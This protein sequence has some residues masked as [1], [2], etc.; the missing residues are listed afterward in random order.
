MT[1]PRVDQI[2]IALIRALAMTLLLLPGPSLSLAQNAD[3]GFRYA[4]LPL[5]EALQALQARGLRIVFTSQTVKPELRVEQEPKASDPRVVLT[6]LLSAHDLTVEPGPGDRLIV[7]K[8]PPRPVSVRGRTLDGDSGAGVRGVRVLIPGTRHST[9]S[10]SEGRFQLPNIPVRLLPAGTL[11]LEARLPGFVVEHIE[12]PL[13]P[14]EVVNV[15]FELSPAPLTVDQIVVVPSQ[16]TLLRDEPVSTVQL[17]RDDLF[18]LPHLGD[19]IFRAFTLLPGVAGEEVSARFHVRG[20]HGD[21]VLVLLDQVELFEPYHMKDYSSSL[22]IIAPS[23]LREVNLMTGGFPAQYGDRMS[24]VLD[25]TTRQPS[26]TRTHLGLGV[27]SAEIGV[28]GTFASDRG[29]WFASARR[30]N[31]DLALDFLGSREQPRYWDAIAKAEL[32]PRPE[33]L[34]GIRALHSDDALDFDAIEPD[35]IEDYRTSYGN[36][37]L[38][39]THQAILGPRLFVDTA[40]SA[41]RVRRDRRGNEIELEEDVPESGAS[42][43]DAVLAMADLLSGSDAEADDPDGE[44]LDEPG[45]A[46]PGFTLVDKRR[47]DALGVRQDWSYQASDDHYLTWGFEARRLITDYDYFNA[48]ELEDPLA[49]LRTEPRTGTVRFQRRLE[50]EQYSVY[51]SDRLRPRDGLTLELGLRYDEQ[52]LTRDRHASP[53]ANLVYALSPS[54]TVRAAWGFFYQSQRPYELQVE[55]GIN[56][57]VQAERTEQRVLGYEQLLGGRANLLLRVEAYHRLISNPRPRYENVYEPISIYPEVEPD[58]F[59][60]TPES[61]EAYGLE[62]FLRGRAGSRVDWWLSYTYARVFDR[63]A[64]Q[65][66]RDVPRRID[67]P[68]AL[69]LDANLQL[70]E[71]WNLNLAWRYHTGWPTTEISGRLEDDEDGEVQVVPVFGPRN[72]E[73]L[74]AYH[75]LDLRAS[76]EWQRRT[77]V[78]G[79]FLEIQNVYDR[80]NVAGF[81]TD[82]EFEVLPDGSVHFLPVEEPWGG[83]LPSFGVT[84]DF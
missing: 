48:R 84:W 23:A 31:L 72:A 24:G 22:S 44:D 28:S 19:D 36:S 42:A 79:F 77:G 68:H 6:E 15:A 47:L 64:V 20:G 76:R 4:G 11:T 54:S 33:Q 40:V 65:P 59:L 55:D 39:L 62:L 2:C 10:D 34:I 50:G 51:V 25:M 1:R 29:H 13:R 75:R 60:V 69:N 53:R 83:F 9:L 27:L 56:E 58:R 78:L 26:S 17:D 14:G 80:K 38:W 3:S 52:T 7:V 8:A 81:D 70:G 74:P 66:G 35:T 12:L 73:R 43:L 16:M 37:Y 61:S 41:G 32:R 46:I 71:H 18:A 57:L 49:A 82:P 67:Q 63:L 45:D 30:G 21:E 5:T